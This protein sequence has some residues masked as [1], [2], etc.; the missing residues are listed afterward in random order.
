VSQGLHWIET[1]GFLCRQPG[2]KKG[3]GCHY[4]ASRDDRER[5]SHANAE[6]KNLKE[7]RQEERADDTESDA[8]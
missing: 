8:D 6:Q 3:S 5:V 2:R 4:G 7:T 1:R